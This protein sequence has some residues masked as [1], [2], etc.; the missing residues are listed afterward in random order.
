M[1]VSLICFLFTALIFV[2]YGKSFVLKFGQ[3]DIS[4]YNGFD[5]F[6]IGLCLTGT[7]LNTWSLFLPV[8]LFSLL[9]LSFGAAFLVYFNKADFIPF[10][11]S[12]RKQ[13]LD[14]KIFLFLSVIAILITLLYGLVTPRN[15]D[16]YLYH[17]N[18]IQWNEMYGTVP[19]LAN[20]HDRFGLNSS[21]FVLSAAFSYNFLYNQ[22]I[23]TISSLCYLVLFIW[24]LKQTVFKK[25]IIGF[26]SVLFIYFFTAQYA[27]DISSPGTDLLPNIIVGYVLLSLLFDG[28]ILTKKT[29]LFIILSLFCITLKLSSFPIIL[30]G[31]WAVYLRNKKFFKALFQFSGFGCLLILPWMT[32]NVM[33]TGYIIY[34]MAE[35]DLFNFDWEVSKNSV[36]DIKKWITSWARIPMKNHDEVLAMPFKEWFSVWWNASLNI[37]KFFYLLAAAAPLSCSSYYL[38]N[39]KIEKSILIT[40][41]V[42]YLGLT[43]WFVTAPDVRFSFTFVLFLA[44]L[45]LFFFKSL[46]DKVAE[47]IN[48]LL[49]ISTVYCLFLMGK[50]GYRLF[51]EDYISAGNFSEYAYLPL[52][53][54]EVKDKRNIKF[55][56]VVLL[57][58]DGRK[59]ELFEPNPNHAQCFDKFPCSWYIDQRLKLRGEDLKDGFC[60]E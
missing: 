38:I 47:K 36:L 49:I 13:I 42:A 30:I 39:K 11:S 44:L 32:K 1:Y 18:A 20:F 26:F 24:L 27:N 59:I 29:H 52:D 4:N 48:P 25:G 53:P 9:F 31:L 19:G 34:P 50:N 28:E 55:N 2:V 12:L 45:P 6:F 46:V 8:D 35:V 10:F 23:F 40:I 33:L 58:K 21:V 54:S 43:F 56:S 57:T 7:L 60:T 41:L 16:S 15:Y 22:Y 37:N 17:I 14:N 3:H 51:C 5:F